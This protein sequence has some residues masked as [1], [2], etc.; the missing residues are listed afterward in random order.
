MCE[1]VVPQLQ[2]PDPRVPFHGFGKRRSQ[3][4]ED[5]GR[6]VRAVE[7]HDYELHYPGEEVVDAYVLL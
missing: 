4:I 1:P 2:A 7:L 5:A 6:C 3:V